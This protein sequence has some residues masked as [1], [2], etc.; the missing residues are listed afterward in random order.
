MRI[1]SL[2]YNFLKIKFLGLFFFALFNQLNAQEASN[3]V[4]TTSI[5]IGEQIN[6]KI[7][8][9]LDSLDE[10]N[11]P[12]AKDFAPFELINEFKVD[13]NYLDKKFIIS[14]QFALTFFDS[15]TYYIPS[16]KLS[17]LDKEIELDSFKVTINAVKITAL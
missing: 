4:D 7:N 3:F 11:F 16:Q 13:T 14:K 12:K 1:N 15:G 5:R 2:T 9:K 10:I 6:Y 8:I 17:L